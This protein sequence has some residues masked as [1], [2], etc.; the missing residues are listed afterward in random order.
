MHG[1]VY[2]KCPIFFYA[3]R[4]EC[5]GRWSAEPLHINSSNSRS[6]PNDSK[7]FPLRRLGLVLGP[8]Q[9]PSQW[10]AATLCLKEKRQERGAKQSPCLK[11]MDSTV[12]DRTA[13]TGARLTKVTNV[14]LQLVLDKKTVTF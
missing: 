13:W 11:A 6:T 9:A 10:I 14:P 4:S 8:T 12:S 1:Q 3:Y 5:D 2:L 7:M